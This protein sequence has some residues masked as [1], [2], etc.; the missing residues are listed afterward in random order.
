MTKRLRST[1]RWLLVCFAIVVS[2]AAATQW[3]AIA[4]EA[5]ARSGFKGDVVFVRGGFNVF[6]GGLDALA[7]KLGKKG[8]TSRIYRH[9]QVNQIV[10]SIRRNQKLYGRRPIILIGHSWGANTILNVARI[11]RD[12]KL[13]VRYMVTIAATNPNVAPGNI[14]KLTNYYFKQNGWGKPVQAVK[15]FRGVLKNVDMSK[16][17]QVHHFNVDDHPE[18]HSHII[19]NVVRF[20]RAKKVAQ[21]KP[22]KNSG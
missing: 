3:S 12:H 9:T 6:S 1:C 14:Q 10:R 17:A 4:A 8:V 11:L 16:D 18:V 7:Q 19:N 22:R 13:N 20:L 5:A 21:R 2:G 15:D